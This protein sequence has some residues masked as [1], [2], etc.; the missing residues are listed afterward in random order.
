MD[1]RKLTV[2]TIFFLKARPLLANGIR[3]FKHSQSVATV[4]PAIECPPNV[5]SLGH[6]IAGSTVTPLL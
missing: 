1:Y 3:V 6:S 5:L 4:V 2:Y